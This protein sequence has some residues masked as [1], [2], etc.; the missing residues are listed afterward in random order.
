MSRPDAYDLACDAALLATAD[1]RVPQF[2]RVPFG[3]QPFHARGNR[4]EVGVLRLSEVDVGKYL[5]H[6]RRERNLPK[7]YILSEPL[8][9]R[10][11]LQPL[12]VDDFNAF[13]LGFSQTEIEQ[14]K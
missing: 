1:K 3:Q 5:F 14:N 13:Q 10:F 2:V 7:Y 4:V 9:A 8:L 6:L 12:I 11:A